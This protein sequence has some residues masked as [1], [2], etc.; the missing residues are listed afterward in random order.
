[1]AKMIMVI[2]KS[3]EDAN[4]SPKPQYNVVIDALFEVPKYMMENKR[5][6]YKETKFIITSNE[7]P[8]CVGTIAMQSASDRRRSLA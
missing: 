1:M 8:I 5:F 6:G 4:N 7:D 2:D 3:L